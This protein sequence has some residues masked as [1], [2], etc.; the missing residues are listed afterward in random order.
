MIDAT[1]GSSVTVQ[2]PA[3]I[4]WTLTVLGRRPDGFH[5][6]ESLVSA[7]TLADT[8]HFTESTGSGVRIRCQSEVGTAGD[9]P[10]DERNLV[11][12][13]AIRLS[14]KVGRDC[15]LDC[16]LVKRIPAGG[17][18]GGGSSNAAATLLALNAF[19]HLGLRTEQLMEIAAE[20]GSDVP[21]F[22][23]D[24]PVV[25]RGRGERLEAAQ[26]PWDGWIVLLIP[27]FGT[28]TAQVYQAWQNDSVSKPA[29][30]C[31]GA[32]QMTAM[33]WLACT[34]NMLEQPAGRV[35]P[36]LTSLMAL[37]ANRAGRPVRLSGSGSTLY[38]VFDDQE[39][40]VAFSRQAAE[41]VQSCVVR[42]IVQGTGMRIELITG[43]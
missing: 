21:L 16:E 8:L 7:I 26:L 30:R 3:K 43:R 6:I 37:L 39:Q 15:R 31:S 42:P 34:Y 18:L 23:H 27:D 5:E 4:N 19:W 28:S 24:G 2:S 33:A 1:A 13:A 29:W 41:F 32:S 17:G 40:A 12:R 35:Y 36:Q 9:V 14:Q 22:L 25:M 11:Y 38:T 10:T 20:L